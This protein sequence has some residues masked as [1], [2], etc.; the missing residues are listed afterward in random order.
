MT[1]SNFRVDEV[2]DLRG[3]GGLVVVGT[4][5]DGEPIGTPEL[6]DEQ[7]GHRIRVLGVDFPIPRTLRTGQT[8]LIVDRQ[9]GEYATAG[10]IWTT[11]G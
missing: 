4:Y 6:L 8:I 7:T 9:D 3:R 5:F 11:A 2:F 10:R 1:A